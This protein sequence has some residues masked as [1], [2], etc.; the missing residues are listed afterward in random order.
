MEVI[1]FRFINKGSMKAS[2]NLLIPKWGYFIIRDICLFEKGNQRWV[3]FPSKVVEKDGQKKYFSYFTFQN[4]ET[5]K[6][7]QEKVLQAID[8]YLQKHPEGTPQEKQSSDPHELKDMSQIL[9]NIPF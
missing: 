8:I 6:Q 1:Y 9:M 7:F 4:Q 2:F 3:S 5:L